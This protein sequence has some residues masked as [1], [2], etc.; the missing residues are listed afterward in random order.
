MKGSWGFGR[1]MKREKR[2]LRQQYAP[3]KGLGKRWGALTVFVQVQGTV[4]A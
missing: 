4:P 1:S 2:D 3:I